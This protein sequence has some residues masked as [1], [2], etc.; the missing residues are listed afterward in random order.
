M[1]S[2]LAQD[3]ADAPHVL[4]AEEAVSGLAPA[5]LDEPLTFEETDLGDGELG[6]LVLERRD[7]LADA[8]GGGVNHRPGPR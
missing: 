5:R 2:L 3:V 4:V 8:A 7:D 1:V 6:E